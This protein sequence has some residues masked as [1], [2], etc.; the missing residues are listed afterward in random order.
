MLLLFSFLSWKRRVKIHSLTAF[1][2]EIKFLFI[3]FEV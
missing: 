2:T 3:Y 1:L